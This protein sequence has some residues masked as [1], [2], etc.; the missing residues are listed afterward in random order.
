[1]LEYWIK[2]EPSFFWFKSIPIICLLLLDKKSDRNGASSDHI[3]FPVD[4]ITDN[5]MPDR[6]QMYPYLMSSASL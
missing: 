4:S 6:L 5:R 1:M 2:K 3:S